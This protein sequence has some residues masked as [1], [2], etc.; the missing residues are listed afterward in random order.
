MFR[1]YCSFSK[2]QIKFISDIPEEFEYSNIGEAN[3]Q[4]VK[5]FFSSRCNDTFVLTLQSGS[6]RLIE[7]L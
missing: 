7:F 2:R 1:L 5:V 3:L 4:C 6:N